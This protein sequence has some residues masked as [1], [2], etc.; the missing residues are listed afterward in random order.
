[1]YKLNLQIG[2]FSKLCGVSVKTLRHYEKM[3]LLMPAEV[4]AFTGYRYYHV[5]QMQQ[6]MTI[7]HLK[8]VGFSLDEIADLLV[9]DT[10]I[11]DHSLLLAKIR[12]TQE[13]LY[14]LIQ[15]RD[16]LL[17]MADSRKK[18]NN[19]KEI[20]I[21]SL[22]EVT[23]ASFRRTISNYNELGTL[24]VNVIGPEMARLGCECPLPGYCFSIDHNSEFASGVIDLEYCESVKEAKTDSDLITFKHLPEVPM[25]VCVKCYGPYDRLYEH[26]VD[27]F[28]YIDQEGYKV[29]G[30]PRSCYVDGIWNEENPERWLTIIQIPVDKVRERIS[31]PSNR[32]KLFVCPNC[33]ALMCGYGNMEMICC[34]NHLQSVPVTKAEANERP[35]VEEYDGEY[36]LRYKHEMSK[37]CYIAGVIAER[38]DRVEIVRLFPEQEALVHLPALTGAKIYTVY[39][40]GDKVWASRF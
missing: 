22:P 15:R 28:A 21:Q 30:Q 39:R 9:C 13:Q 37:E 34:G 31:A 35:D 27:A 1:M 5:E 16:K 2:E 11:P 8:D 36:V 20:S 32:L 23:V 4:D 24:C 10:Q 25:A 3:G 17:E 38:Y 18:I 12:D 26:F 7:R 14:Q 6:M 40:R 19:M 33:G 29:T